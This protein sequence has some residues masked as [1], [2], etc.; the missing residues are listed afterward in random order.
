MADGYPHWFSDNNSDVFLAQKIVNLRGE[1]RPNILYLKPDSKA[2]FQPLLDIADEDFGFYIL[3]NDTGNILFKKSSANL[4]SLGIEDILRFQNNTKEAQKAG[5][6]VLSVPLQAQPW[7]ILFYQDTRTES[8]YAEKMVWYYMGTIMAMLLLSIFICWL[9]MGN[10]VKQIER[11]TENMRNMVG[12]GNQLQITVYS[13]SK[14]EIGVLTNAFGE[15]IH[16][17]KKLMREIGESE[18]MKREFELKAL[19]SQMNPH[20]LYNTLSVINWKAMERGA[21]DICEVVQL[22]STFYR[23]ALNHGSD[24]ISVENELKNVCSY[25][26]LQQI[27]HDKKIEVRYSVNPDLKKLQIPCFILQPVV[28]NALLH[29]IDAE[30]NR[31]GCIEIS[32]Q[33]ESEKL[34]FA[35]KDNGCGMTEKQIEKIL[36][37]HSNGYGLKN[38]HERIQLYYGKAYGIKI[39]SAPHVG[40]EVTLVLP[41]D[42]KKCLFAQNTKKQT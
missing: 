15:M 40:T 2:L 14:D 37:T 12:S 4:K 42:D 34:V 19:R 24:M 10:M 16:S 26:Q 9:F 35:V 1:N 7:T 6:S 22:L 36:T 27:M 8:G 11:L 21:D 23:T 39:N 30:E 28:E 25:I 20:F 3:E 31:D 5:V 38:V 29:G 17:I 13:D 33:K 32:C 18:E 41:I